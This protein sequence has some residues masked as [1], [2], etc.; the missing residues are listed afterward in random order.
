M[1]GSPYRPFRKRKR[2][3]ADPPSYLVHMRFALDLTIEDML[4]QCCFSDDLKSAYIF[5]LP[6]ERCI[7]VDLFNQS[8]Q[9][10]VHEADY[11]PPHS[12]CRVF[13]TKRFLV[14]VTSKNIGI[15]PLREF[16]GV[17]AVRPLMLTDKSV[18]NS[19]LSPNGNILVVPTV[20][21]DMEFFQIFHSGSSSELDYLKKLLR[22]C[23][24]LITMLGWN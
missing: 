9:S 13:F 12:A 7:Y 15:V 19:K 1:L 5:E 20:T 2:I 24:E 23:Q 8:Y 3:E 10:R 18:L 11:M 17:Q 4:F 21:G 14:I 6:F 16:K 22:Q